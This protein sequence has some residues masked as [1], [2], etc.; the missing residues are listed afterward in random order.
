MQTAVGKCFYKDQVN[1][2]RFCLLLIAYC[3]PLNNA[4][5]QEEKPRWLLGAGITYDNYMNTPGINLNATYRVMGNF[6][7]GPDFSA[8]LNKEEKENGITV[9]KKELEYNFNAT[10][11]FELNKVL[12]IYPLAGINFSKVTVHPINQEPAKKVITALN[13][14]G[15][16]EVELKTLKL[17]CESKYVSQ[18]D[19]YDITLGALFRL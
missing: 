18:L 5:A 16:L 6:H 1:R 13:I 2:S 19:K 17:F 4:Y 8:L 3:L 7:I 11:L 12:A 9:L 14:G 10:Q 15:G